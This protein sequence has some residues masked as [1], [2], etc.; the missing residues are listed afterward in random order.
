MKVPNL[1]RDVCV[2]E[3]PVENG[4]QVEFGV[5]VHLEHLR[6]DTVTLTSHY[7]VNIRGCGAQCSMLYKRKHQGRYMGVFFLLFLNFATVLSHLSV[8]EA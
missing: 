3:S 6:P 4:S 5:S 8:W 1:N 7:S 2:G